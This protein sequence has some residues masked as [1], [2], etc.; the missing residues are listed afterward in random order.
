[1][2]LDL[3]TRH[4]TEAGAI[5][6]TL[7]QLN[8]TLH[9][10]GLSF[11]VDEKD[12]EGQ[13]TSYPAADVPADALIVLG[14]FDFCYY[15]D[16]E[17]L[18]YGVQTHN[19]PPQAHWSDHW[20]KPQLELVQGNEAQV[21]LQQLQWEPAPQQKLFAFN[22]GSHGDSRYYILA[23]GLSWHIGVAFHYDR[24]AQ[25]PLQPGQRVVY[26]VHKAGKKV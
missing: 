20:Q 17:L 1:M 23:L 19:L 2:A 12:E 18:F 6:A 24:E 13:Y 16:L 10:A 22:V 9:N 4:Y 26:W 3:H 8:T 15:H 14:S 7:Q 21:V 11:W 25:E 5:Q